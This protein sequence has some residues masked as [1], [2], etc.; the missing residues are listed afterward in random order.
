VAIDGTVFDLPDTPANE[1]RFGRP[2]AGRGEA[3]GFFPQARVVALAECGTH[4]IIGAEIGPCTSD[5]MTF[6]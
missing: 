6:T 1:E 2:G 3:Q 5:E 4:A